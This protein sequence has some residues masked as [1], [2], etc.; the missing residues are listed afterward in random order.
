MTCSTIRA[1]ASRTAAASRGA[2]STSFGSYSTSRPPNEAR[3]A[4]SSMNSLMTISAIDDSPV[5]SGGMGDERVD[6]GVQRRRDAQAFRG[7]ARPVGE[8]AR[9]RQ[10]RARFSCDRID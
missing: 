7:G 1:R 9:A 5:R 10:P 3:M 6:L 4:A 2:S 8:P